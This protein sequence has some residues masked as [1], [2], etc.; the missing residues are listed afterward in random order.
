MRK[1]QNNSTETPILIMGVCSRGPYH[2]VKNILNNSDVKWMSWGYFV[3]YIHPLVIKQIKSRKIKSGT[4]AIFA[5]WEIG[6]KKRAIL[7]RKGIIDH[8]VF[9]NEYTN[10]TIFLK[11][12]IS[13]FIEFSEKDHYLCRYYNIKEVKENNG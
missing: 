11:E 3:N 2:Y 13:G 9:K 1:E 8:I 4:E 10:F 12:K 5:I 7:L 6:V